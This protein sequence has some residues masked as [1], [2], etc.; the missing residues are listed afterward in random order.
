MIE[1]NPM[2][3][4]IENLLITITRRLVRVYEP[5]KIF[6]F[7]SYAYGQPT[8]DSDLDLMVV[9]KHSSLPRFKRSR[10]GY[11]QLHDIAFPVELLVMTAEE[12]KNLSTVKTSLARKCIA[13][14]RI[15]Y[16]AE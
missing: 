13:K 12:L 10:K 7:S 15:L 14:G 3:H 1:S 8:K 6:S 9:V 2:K 4:S 5:E 16:G 11:A